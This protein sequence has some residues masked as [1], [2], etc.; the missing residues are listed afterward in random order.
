MAI[1]KKVLSVAAT[2]LFTL[3]IALCVFLFVGKMNGG[4]TMLFDNE[5]MVVLS[6]SMAPTFQT[7]SIVAVKP[8]S[9]EQI[10][11]GDII[12]FKDLDG[13]TVTHRVVEIKDSQLVTKG[14][15][16]DG[17]DYN[18]VSK[19]RVI[20]EVQYWVPLLGYLVEF[21]RS[22]VGM[23]VFLVVPGVYLIVSQVW[24]LFRM[25]K[26]ADAPVNESR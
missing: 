1:V 18:P 24:K 22:Q 14:D 11:Q 17:N 3:I 9:F 13:R 6:G 23:L 12:T 21:I 7:G 20:G 25:L 15:A 5:L 8:V 2:I 26:E 10:K 19:D 4:K 16:N